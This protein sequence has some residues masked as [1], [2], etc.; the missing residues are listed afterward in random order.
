MAHRRG[1]LWHNRNFLLLWSGQFISGLGTGVSQFAFPLLT[2]AI[3]GSPA[4]TGFVAFLGQVPYFLLG[5][6]VGA[7]VDR[8]DRRRVMLVSRVG[9][10]L[11]LLSIPLVLAFGHL[12]V[13]PLDVIA[14]V[15][16]IFFVFLDPAETSSLP[17]FVSAEQLPSAT[18]LYLTTLDMTR[19][20]GAPLG[21]LLYGVG[22]VFP[23][24]TDGLSSLVSACSLLFIKASFQ[25]ERVKVPPSLLHEMRQGLKWLWHQPVV[26][27]LTVITGGLNLI[28]PAWTLIVIVIATRQH[29]SPALIGAIFALGEGSY[30]LGTLLGAPLQRKLHLKFIILGACWLFVLLWPLFAVASNL[31]MFAA[32]LLGLS[33]LR[34]MYGTVEVSY[35]LA[36]VP[37]DLRGRVTS[38]NHLFTFGSEP[39]GLALT[40]VL[41]EYLGVV[42]TVLL[43][44]AVLLILAMAMT[45]NPYIRKMRQP[46][47]PL[48]E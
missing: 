5:L 15:N 10:A 33:L 9:H 45:L 7:L 30:T 26:A 20:L 25:Q 12:S 1:P 13:L 23:F 17:Q 27:S 44:G 39:V 46:S 4:Q 3:S 11:S 41:I 6:P 18:S 21:G 16:G 36:R 35:L 38:I 29:V 14:F 37:D 47:K 22:R 2:L 24:V 19:T 48:A 43:L 8:W 32:V 42:R 40:G 34:S 31:L 28:F